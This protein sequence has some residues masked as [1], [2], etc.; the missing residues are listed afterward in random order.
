MDGGDV[1]ASRRQK[2]ID[3]KLQRLIEQ[4]DCEKPEETVA[5]W[6]EYDRALTEAWKKPR[7]ESPL[8]FLIRSDVPIEDIAAA[9]KRRYA[10]RG[11]GRPGGAHT[12]WLLRHLV[13]AWYVEQA[14]PRPRDK[15]DKERITRW[16]DESNSWAAWLRPSPKRRRLD[17]QPGSRDHE[18]V[19]A[20]LR[21]SKRR[22]L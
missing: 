13:I 22:R 18:R 16:I 11:K 9:L 5:A 10:S 6:R 14:T 21:K 2:P 20:L 3:C 7:Q 15:F 19:V 1:T 17:P 8:A 12:R 4:L